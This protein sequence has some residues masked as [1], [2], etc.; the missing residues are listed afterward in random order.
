M[1]KLIKG[2]HKFQKEVFPLKKNFFEELAKEQKPEVLFITCSDSRI[3]PNLVTTTEP[4]DL[5]ILRNAGNIIPLFG[6][7]IGEEAT[8]EF[9]IEQLGIKHI[10]VCGHSYCG[11]IEAAMNPERMNN[12]PSLNKWITSNV[13]PT[14]DLI[15]KNYSNLDQNE[16]FDVLLQE[17]VLKQIENLKSHPSVAKR[18]FGNEVSVHAWIYR[19][20]VGTVYAFNA[21]EEQFELISKGSGHLFL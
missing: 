14:L 15:R 10:I 16:M 9:A 6:T 18:L 13:S 5:F 1:K 19:I 20:E 7:S 3:N 21:A 4:G 17:N 2:L 12:M 8:I 11:A